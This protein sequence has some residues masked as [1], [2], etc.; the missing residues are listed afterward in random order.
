MQIQCIFR[1]ATV[2]SVNNL[3]QK[4]IAFESLAVKTIGVALAECL[5]DGLILHRDNLEVHLP[6]RIHIT[7]GDSVIEG[8]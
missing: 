7:G 4:R 2:S 5:F 3:T 6:N 8:G 1:A